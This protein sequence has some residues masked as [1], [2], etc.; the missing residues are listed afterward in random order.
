MLCYNTSN[1]RQDTKRGTG[2]DTV[3]KAVEASDRLLKL[4][5]AIRKYAFA[6]EGKKCLVG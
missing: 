1:K 4:T 5:L 6:S 3:V 2:W